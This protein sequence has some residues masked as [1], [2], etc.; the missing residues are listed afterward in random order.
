MII[1]LDVDGTLIN[2]H[3]QTPA[4]AKQAVLKARQKKHLVFLCTG[5]SKAEIELR[6]LME[7]DGLILA[8]GA[9][10]EYK[11]EILYHH[12]LNKALVKEIVDWCESK[13]MGFYLECNSGMYANKQM[14]ID[15]EEVMRKYAK[16][17]GKSDSE[18]IN[19]AQNFLKG[20]ILKDREELYRDDVNK[21]SFVLSSYDDY[22]FI[23]NKYQ[24]HEVNTWGGRMELA[25]FGDI[26]PFGTNKG[27]AIRIVLDKLGLSKSEAISFGD[28]KID[29]LM[30]KECGYN[31]AMGNASQDVKNAANFITKDV[32]E[33]GL[34]FAF[35]ELALI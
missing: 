35:K 8:N 29:L 12:V 26:A 24:D 7:V 32:D 33:D 21:I 18:A 22:L 27:Q 9:Y 16:G 13:N 5:C 25:L 11:G 15:G 19:S 31:V 6:D 14:L 30:F 3:A 2:Y 10:I 23:K 20:M 1:F 4:S 17:K 28:A 34:L